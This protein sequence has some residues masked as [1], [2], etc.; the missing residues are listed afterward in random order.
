MNSVSYSFCGHQRLLGHITYLTITYGI[1]FLGSYK[2]MLSILKN[3]SNAMAQLE[4]LF[5]QPIHQSTITK[6]LTCSNQFIRE[7]FIMT[8]K[9]PMRVITSN[10][11]NYEQ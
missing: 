3:T 11:S 10:K 1:Y 2:I 5:H 6:G 8:V 9:K 7:V 4:Q